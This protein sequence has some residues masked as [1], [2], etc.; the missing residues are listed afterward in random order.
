MAGPARRTRDPHARPAR[1][2]V[3]RRD[4]DLVGGLEPGEDLDRLAIVIPDRHG[5]ELRLTIP[6]HGDLESFGPEEQGVGGNG[7]GRDLLGTA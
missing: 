4:D 6:N 7:D 5:N 2:R 1:E 3:R